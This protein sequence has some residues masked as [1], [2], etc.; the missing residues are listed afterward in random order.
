MIS[1]SL[2]YIYR[3]AVYVSVYVRFRLAAFD[4]LKH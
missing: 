1:F 2:L 4:I 3:K